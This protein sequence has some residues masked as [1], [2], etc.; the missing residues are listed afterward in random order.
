MCNYKQDISKGQVLLEK[1]TRKNYKFNDL[2]DNNNFVN[3]LIEKEF[4]NPTYKTKLLNFFCCDFLTINFVTREA[5]LAFLEEYE[6]FS[7]RELAKVFSENYKPKFRTITDNK[8]KEMATQFGLPSIDVVINFCGVTNHIKKPEGF[9][10]VHHQLIFPGTPAKDVFYFLET[11]TDL[12]RK[13]KHNHQYKIKSISRIDFRLQDSFLPPT[14]FIKKKRR[15]KNMKEDENPTMS[16]DFANFVQL[17][18]ASVEKK[19]RVGVNDIPRLF[20]DEYS[21]TFYIGCLKKGR[22]IKRFYDHKEQGNRVFEI[23]F[24]DGPNTPMGEFIIAHDFHSLNC[25]LLL[26]FCKEILKLVHCTYTNLLKIFA[27]LIFDKFLLTFCEGASVSDSN[28]SYSTELTVK[29]WIEK[30]KFKKIKNYF[31]TKKINKKKNL[32][33]FDNAF[34]SY[35]S[36]LNLT[37]EEKFILSII[38][39]SLVADLNK[40]LWKQKISNYRAFFEQEELYTKSYNFEISLKNI[41]IFLN[42]SINTK[43]RNKLKQL[44]NNLMPRLQGLILEHSFSKKFQTDLY[45]NINLSLIYLSSFFKNTSV[46][47][48]DS[49]IF[50][51][52]H[53]NILRSFVI[54]SLNS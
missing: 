42:L 1:P 11:K 2:V 26:N 30:Q 10:A 50:F 9:V 7:Q 52:E 37:A 4:C 12:I 18:F 45:L 13:K 29:S 14:F 8:Q 43:N 47:Y 27:F 23:V 48:L 31:L 51:S 24:R 40:K 38:F 21:A 36:V 3:F 49:K 44:L 33:L 16:I 28:C 34:C 22:C 17:T 25:L 5:S 35:G 53:Y 46:I 19:K 39:R 54:N 32:L 15:K 20:E 6:K 41:L